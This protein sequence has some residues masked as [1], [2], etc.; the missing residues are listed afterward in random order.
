MR[1]STSHPKT[2]R[3]VLA[4]LR[5]AAEPGRPAVPDRRRGGQAGDRGTRS[6][7]SPGAGCPGR[8]RRSHRRRCR[9]LPLLPRPR[10]G[11]GLVP[12]GGTA[13]SST[14]ASAG[15]TAGA[16]ATS[17][18]RARNGDKQAWDALVERYAPLI[19]SICR[20]YRLAD[21]DADDVGQSV[22]LQLVD[23]LGQD[24]R[25]GRAARLAG[26]HHPA[27]MRPGPARGA[28][29]RRAAGSCAGRRGPSRTSRPRRPSRK[30]CGAERHAALREAL[31]HLPVLAASS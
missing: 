15:K 14:R 31:T 23:Q 6:R 7:R 4:N 26:H 13:D 17:W 18:T 24:P 3:W 27:R 21:A 12:R 29:D 25:P 9:R 28:Q 8:T 30:C 20:R 19:W 1:W 10:P 11:N 5:R 16:T 22:W 2:G